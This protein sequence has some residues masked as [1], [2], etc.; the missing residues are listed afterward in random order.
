MRFAL[1]WDI[2]QRKVVIHCRRFGTTYFPILKRQ[3]VLEHKQDYNGR[4]SILLQWTTDS[5][6]PWITDSLLQWTTESLL[7]WITDSLKS[8]LS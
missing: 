2:T 3:E 6:L 7:P 4:E 5:L 1:S 8:V